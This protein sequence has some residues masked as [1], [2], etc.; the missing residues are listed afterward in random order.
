MVKFKQFIFLLL[1]NFVIKIVNKFIFYKKSIKFYNLRLNV[2]DLPKNIVSSI[3][4]KIY[5]RAEIT[6]IL[7][8]FEPKNTIDIGSGLGFNTAVLKKKYLNHNFKTILAEPNKQ[9]QRISKRIFK[10]NNIIKN[11]HFL[12]ILFVG[13]KRKLINFKLNENFLNSKIE[14]SK[15][16]NRIKKIINLKEIIKRYKIKKGFQ[17]IIDIEGEEFK[18]NK[19]TFNCLRNCSKALIEVHYKN[20][21][22]KRQF[23]KQMLN[24][25]K[26]HLI[27]EKS[28][29]LYF[30]K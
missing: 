15:S 19:E 16:K 29:T 4:L 5:E 12:N 24:Y 10:Y 20:N 1:G 23:V 25:S 7:K 21:I 3:F 14:N 22:Q 6:L 26:L 28:F 9:V 30:S 11:T 27:D 18:F 13:K 17:I 2:R 8:Y